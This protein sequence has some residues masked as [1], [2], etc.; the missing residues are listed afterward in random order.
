MDAA[1]GRLLRAK[2]E[3]L[4]LSQVE[5]ARKVKWPQSRLSRVEQGRRSVTL[6][7][8][9]DLARV[10]ACS[11]SALFGELG[12]GTG[13]MAVEP[14]RFSA[15][16]STAFEDVETA[17]AQL[18][19]LGVRFLG[20]G[21]RATLVDL[22][23]EEAVL[24]A[25]RHSRDPRV[26]EALPALV[27]GRARRLDW[28]QLASGAYALRLQNRLGMVVSAALRLTDDG[29]VRRT[30]QAAHD[31]LA[32]AKLDR[33]EVVGPRPKTEAGL[34]ALLKSTPDWLRFWHGMGAGDLE[35]YRR[36]LPR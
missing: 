31:A 29:E 11:V 10:F 25:L 2:R 16:F 9:L 17:L 20:G 22:S 1:F 8:L 36:H 15:G 28:A 19:K 27:L 35:S 23:P 34:A 12:G 24:A 18:E 26:F 21:A 7:E 14:S 30:L 4:R 3:F 5:L 13:A 33:E 6:P 32:Q